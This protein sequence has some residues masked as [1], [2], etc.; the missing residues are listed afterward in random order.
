LLI[1]LLLAH[2]GDLIDKIEEVFDVF[3]GNFHQNS[4]TVQALV[5]LTEVRGMLISLLL[6]HHGKLKE[7]IEEVLDVELIKQQIDS[8]VL[9][10]E[11]YAGYIIGGYWVKIMLSFCDCKL[12]HRYRPYVWIRFILALIEEVNSGF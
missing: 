10:F 6:P 11:K 8:G 5:L 7:K 1:S 9:E 3:A 2:H 12:R 4:L